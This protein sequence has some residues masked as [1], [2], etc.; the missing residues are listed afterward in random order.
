[1]DSETSG[2]EAAVLRTVLYADV[3]DYAL[4]VDEL[5]HFLMGD[6]PTTRDELDSV[7]TASE[8]LRAELTVIDG[9]VVLAGRETL[10]SGRADRDALAAKLW[11]RAV[12]AGKLLAGVPF[13]RMVALT[14]ALAM[15]NPAHLRDDFDYFI[16]TAPGR[17]W[18]ARL[19][20][21]GVVRLSRLWGWPVCPNFVLSPDALAQR[22]CDVYIAHEIAQA[23]PLDD[24]AG[25]YDRFRAANPWTRGYLPNALDAYP[26]GA[27]RPLGRVGRWFK[28]A[29]EWVLGGKLGDRLEMWEQRRKLRRFAT[30]AQRR[31]STAQLDATQV[32]G[33]FNDHGSRVI[34]AYRDRL[35]AFGLDDIGAAEIAAD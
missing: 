27:A 34:A 9:L 8:R 12:S 31:G 10:I 19:L 29:G 6:R 14:G 11:P 23:V 15:H 17:V 35:R 16:V 20:I 32:K 13:V 21:V 1:M 7:L 24:R 33:H 25:L 4:R 28:Q 26:R 30:E 22:R 18:L 2:L 3:F 5:H